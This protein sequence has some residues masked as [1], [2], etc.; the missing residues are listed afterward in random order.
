[1]FG[2]KVDLSV[3]R[4]KDTRRQTISHNA[5]ERGSNRRHNL[6]NESVEV[7]V[8]GPFNIEVS[9]ADIVNGFIVNHKCTVGMFEGGVGG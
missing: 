3:S 7:G 4:Q 2:I 9:A 5:P 8:G 1:M 6:A